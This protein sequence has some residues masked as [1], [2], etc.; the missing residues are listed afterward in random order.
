MQDN[1]MKQQQL[2]EMI[3]H[4]RRTE[5]IQAAHYAALS[6]NTPFKLASLKRQ[7]M[8]M[9][10]KQ[11]ANDYKNNPSLM[12]DK[13]TS[14]SKLAQQYA[15]SNYADLMHSMTNNFREDPELQD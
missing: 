8:E 14:Q 4:N 7:A 5:G 11:A 12:M 9:G 1:M 13:T 6:N 10:I 2:Q 3:T 15:N